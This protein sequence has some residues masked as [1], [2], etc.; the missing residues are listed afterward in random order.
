MKEFIVMSARI[1]SSPVMPSVADICVLNAGKGG[2]ARLRGVE[3]GWRSN[4]WGWGCRQCN[5]A[6]GKSV[7]DVRGAWK[8]SSVKQLFH[9]HSVQLRMAIKWHWS[10]Q[11]CYEMKWNKNVRR[12]RN[13]CQPCV[14][15]PVF[16][17]FLERMCGSSL[18]NNIKW[19]IIQS[20]RANLFLT[21]I[22]TI[23]K[24]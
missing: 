23:T 9:M 18:I 5:A 13:T 1:M 6:T 19:I 2:W 14:F 12:N 17:D 21:F 4:L 15:V 24:K 22:I 7:E 8:G 3:S 10:C 16:Q 11:V 20:S